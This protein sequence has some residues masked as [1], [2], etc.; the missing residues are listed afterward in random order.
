MTAA[1]ATVLA[2]ISSHQYGLTGA[3]P[4]PVGE[5]EAIGRL[6]R[7]T[8]TLVSMRVVLTAA[9]C[10][11]P[12]EN[13]ALGCSTRT[14]FTLTNVRPVDDPATAVDESQTRRDL[15]IAGSVTIHPQYTAA[16]WLRKDLAVVTLDRPVW[17][18]ATGIRPLQ[19]AD[20]AH[21]VAAGEDVTIVGFGATGKNCSAASA[22]KRMLTL[23]IDEIVP[24]AIRFKD[25]DRVSCPGDSG[26]PALNS[27]GWI[28]GV[29][30]WTNS[31]DESTYRPVWES[32]EWIRGI[33]ALNEE[34][35]VEGT[36]VTSGTTRDLD[37]YR[38]PRQYRPKDPASEIVGMAIA[39]DDVVFAWYLDG[40]VSA[41]NSTD[42]SSRRP[43]NGYTLPPGKAP[44]DIVDV[45]IARDSR[46]Y[47]WYRDGTVS[48]G[49]S[50]DL[51]LHRPAQ[52]YTLPPGR[53]PQDL[54]GI[55]IAK[56]S[57]RVFA[58]Y[59]DGTVSSGNSRDL[60]ASTPP[61]PV[62]FP[63]GR[64]GRDLVGVG[65]A[66]SDDHVFAWFKPYLH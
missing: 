31:F 32:H 64:S 18:V 52:P 36:V 40:T 17:E 61:Q 42:L 41:G 35:P 38:G 47:A 22:G 33:V 5:F 20:P 28:V 59:S 34:A 46:V 60:D 51:T 66:G 56:S 30:S 8:G 49:S 63:P 50:S 1:P 55:A 43:P 14:Q 7:C 11:C 24:D 23:D 12:S 15:T 10:E 65:I 27:D 6:P 44:A 39:P 62:A 16:G 2:Q 45:A 9:H 53:S 19:F 3:Q 48:S 26:G 4:V 54:A 37:H 58:W 29:A 25:P 21:P 13:N 57:D